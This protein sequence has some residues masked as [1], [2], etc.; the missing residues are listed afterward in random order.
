MLL[1]T[2][3]IASAPS[4]ALKDVGQ[5]EHVTEARPLPDVGALMR[6]VEEHQRQEELVLKDYIYRS[7]ETE[8]EN[9]GHGA[10]KKRTVRT[11]DA[12]WLQGVP[13]RKLVSKD[14]TPL[15]SDELRKEDERIDKEVAKAKQKREKNDA[16]GKET[17]PRGHEEVTVARV[18][19]LGVFSNERR[20]QLS[21]RDTIA[22]DYAGDPKAKTQN[23]VEEVIRDLV[24]T[25][26]VDEQD[27]TIVKLEGHFLNAFKIGGGLVVSI[28]PNTNFSMERRKVNA[29]AWLPVEVEGHGA[30]RA[31]LF[32]NFDGSLRVE[33][34]EFRKFKG[35]VSMLPGVGMVDE[36]PPKP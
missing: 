32:F 23:R 33:N 4:Q 6:K 2:L 31:M 16:K 36:A 27:T 11:Y 14:G 8:E 5:N 22:V 3:A 26:W 21:G 20:V 15:S 18:L 30:A 19:E 13:V 9:D 28:R 24:G 25:L 35:S 1:A 17:S 29:E 7:V 34:S 12:F 10:I